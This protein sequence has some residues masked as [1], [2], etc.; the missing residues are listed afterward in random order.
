MF[1][2]G[3]EKTLQF[4]REFNAP[5]EK[6]W[7]AFTIPT[8]LTQW[9]GPEGT[10]IPECEMDVKVGGKIRIVMEA[11][12]S[13]GSYAG[14]RWPLEGHFTLVKQHEQLQYEALAWTEGRKDTTTIDQIN[15]VTLTIN[16]E[17]TNMVFIVTIKKTGIKASMA[18]FGMK[19]GYA[20]Q[21]KKLEQ[22]FNADN[23]Q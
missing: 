17:K 16:G 4:E 14:T 2:F 20:S 22:L 1:L 10:T 7:D 21:F 19:M 13:M 18:A 11:G 5:V 12:K 3:K 9:W 6:V 8:I 15:D 23:N